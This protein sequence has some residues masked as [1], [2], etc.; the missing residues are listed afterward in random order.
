MMPNL[1]EVKNGG[2]S[3]LGISGA[4]ADGVVALPGFEIVQATFAKPL[5]LEQAF[6]SIATYLE[7]HN[8]PMQAL[9]AL[10]L[11][12]PKTFSPAEFGTFN[13]GY[14]KLLEHYHI[15][16]DGK[17]PLARTNVVPVSP[18]DIPSVYTFSYTMPSQ[19]QRKTFVAAGVG[20]IRDDGSIIRS[21]ETSEEA[22]LE[23]IQF[24]TDA[25]RKVVEQLGVNW[26]DTTRLNFYGLQSLPSNTLNLLEGATRHGITWY[27]SVPPIAGLDAEI[28]VRGVHQEF[29]DVL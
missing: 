18:P 11:R 4:I 16:I 25:L 21:G 28:D 24:I 3:S 6:Q 13:Q 5:P 22:W 17:S 23:K 27:E 14:L 9:C 12:S 26:Q 7:H 19:E 8:R 29:F 15:L 2:Y 1:T 10:Q 20:D